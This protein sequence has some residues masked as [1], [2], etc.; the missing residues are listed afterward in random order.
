MARGL[1]WVTRTT[2]SAP[3]RPKLSTRLTR[4]KALKRD[5]PHIAWQVGRGAWFDP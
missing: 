5:E 1:E 4:E 3:E 2:L